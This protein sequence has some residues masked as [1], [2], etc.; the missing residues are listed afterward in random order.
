[1][2][3]VAAGGQN[4]VCQKSLE[5]MFPFVNFMFSH[6]EIWVQRGGLPALSPTRKACPPLHPRTRFATPP[7]ICGQ[8]LPALSVAGKSGPH[9]LVS[10]RHWLVSNR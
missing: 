3:P 5:S 2:H 4:F 8:N 7:S 1:M 6:Y 9:R 10:N